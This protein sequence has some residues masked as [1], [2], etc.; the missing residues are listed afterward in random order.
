MSP[1]GEVIRSF[2]YDLAGRLIE[3]ADANGIATCYEYNRAGW[4]V[5]KWEPVEESKEGI[6]Y[7]LTCYAYDKAGN[8]IQEKRSGKAVEKG[9]YPAQWLILNFTYDK[10]NRLIKVED[11]L[12][13]A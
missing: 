1:E 12:G 2:V 3:E 13:A 7:N 8:K 5:R 9:S 6:L 10:R 4:L 11:S